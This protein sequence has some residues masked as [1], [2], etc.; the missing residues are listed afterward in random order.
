MWEIEL[1]LQ[2]TKKASPM[3]R[4]PI[5]P[6]TGNHIPEQT[7]PTN[8]PFCLLFSVICTISIKLNRINIQYEFCPERNGGESPEGQLR[9]ERESFIVFFFIEKFSPHR[10]I[11]STKKTNS[12]LTVQHTQNGALNNLHTK[13]RTVFPLSRCSRNPRSTTTEEIFSDYC[14]LYLSLERREF[15][16]KVSPFRA[17]DRR[18]WKIGENIFGR[19]LFS[20]FVCAK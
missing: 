5:K 4:S 13:A 14:W 1:S 17:L 12:K 20:C 6:T 19:E 16:V 2:S 7:F 9:T 11:A 18:R 3:G 10:K 8:F 15:R